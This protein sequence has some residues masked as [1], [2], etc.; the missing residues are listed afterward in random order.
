MGLGFKAIR[1]DQLYSMR[2]KYTWIPESVIGGLKRNGDCNP[3]I[4]QPNLL[5]ETRFTPAVVSK[6]KYNFKVNQCDPKQIVR[7]FSIS[8]YSTNS[9]K[10][11][12]A[13]INSFL[14]LCTYFSYI[15][16]SAGSRKDIFILKISSPRRRNST[17]HPGIVCAFRVACGRHI[18]AVSRQAI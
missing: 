4:P 10:K 3:T 12:L 17:E 16:C 14:V 1:E 7:S 11:C 13:R 18:I 8:N 5:F 15:I 6:V 2:K 9:N